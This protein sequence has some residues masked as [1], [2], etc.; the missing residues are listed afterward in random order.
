MQGREMPIA[1]A[2]LQ[3]EFAKAK[4]NHVLHQC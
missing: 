3:L 1:E 2:R 4:H